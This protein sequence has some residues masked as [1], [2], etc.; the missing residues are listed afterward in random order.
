MTLFFCLALL[1]T[2]VVAGSSVEDVFKEVHTNAE[3]PEFLKKDY[4]F[5]N[6]QL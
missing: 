5:E 4:S 3:L 6:G 1:F 2:S